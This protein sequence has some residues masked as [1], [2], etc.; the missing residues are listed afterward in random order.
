MREIK[1]RAWNERKGWKNK[2]GSD[3]VPQMEYDGF[4][5][6]PDGKKEFP[7]G[8]WDLSGRDE[9]MTLMQ[10]TGLKDKNGKE[11]YEGD[12][13]KFLVHYPADFQERNPYKRYGRICGPVLW[14]EGWLYADKKE[15]NGQ[16]DML[17]YQSSS[18]E[19]EIIGNIYQN[20]ELLNN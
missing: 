6:Y 10:Y 19:F 17:L 16:D 9:E 18:Q 15:H 11:I 3:C 12:I 1:F 7:Q 8:G 4:V 2:D 5:I 14:E 13:L 20:P